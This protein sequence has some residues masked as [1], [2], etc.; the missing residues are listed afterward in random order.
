MQNISQ[1]IKKVHHNNLSQNANTTKLISKTS[2]RIDQFI[3]SIHTHSIDANI[4]ATG[5]TQIMKDF[6][7][8][9]SSIPG[10]SVILPV[11]D[12]TNYGKII[13]IVNKSTNNI[14]LLPASGQSL[15]GAQTNI[16]FSLPNNGSITLI[17]LDNLSWTDYDSGTLS[18]IVKGISN[19]EV[20][21]TDK[22]GR[23]QILYSGTNSSD[24]NNDSGN[25][26]NTGNILRLGSFIPDGDI[27]NVISE[28]IVIYGLPSNSK[29]MANNSIGLARIRPGSLQIRDNIGNGT[30]DIFRA[31]KYL[32]TWREGGGNIDR[33]KVDPINTVFNNNIV[34]N[35]NVV[36][37]VD[38]GN[39]KGSGYQ[40]NK[41]FTLVESGTTGVVL[42]AQTVIGSEYVIKNLSGDTINIYP[43]NNQ[44][45]D[46]MNS[47]I[48]LSSGNSLRVIVGKNNSFYVI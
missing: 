15:L 48:S 46:E 18:D 35:Q 31:D 28:G 13:R 21:T 44:T 42:P 30:Y 39:N 16:P 20:G 12:D 27:S 24:P 1:V 11:I 2:S 40:I 9:T 17:S 33:I 29:P 7:I 19:F 37:T 34:A 45:I 6:N 14:N 22:F 43:N 3:N 26:S 47:M 4:I 8:I 25:Y 41:Y 10:A 5:Q 36:R 23:R 32:L 38:I